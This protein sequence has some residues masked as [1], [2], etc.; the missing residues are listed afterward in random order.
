M[1]RTR[2]P[3][4][5][6]PIFAAIE[7]HRA[8]AAELGRKGSLLPGNSDELDKLEE[9]EFE[10]L[11]GLVEIRPTTRDGAI[12]LLRYVADVGSDRYYGD[13]QVPCSVQRNVAD[14]LLQMEVQS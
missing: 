4:K 10:K 5:A 6:D 13:E 11:C 2:Q 14:V 7:A 8:A 3:K 1:K 9:A 12:A